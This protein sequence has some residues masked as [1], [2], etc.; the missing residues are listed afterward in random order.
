MDYSQITHRMINQEFQNQKHKDYWREK[1]RYIREQTSSTVNIYNPY[2]STK[3]MAH[4]NI[5]PKLYRKNPTVNICK[6]SAPRLSNSWQPNTN[7]LYWLK[8]IINSVFHHQTVSN[9]RWVDDAVHKKGKIESQNPPSQDR[10]FQSSTNLLNCSIFLPWTEMATLLDPN[11]TIGFN[12]P[13]WTNAMPN[14]PFCKEFKDKLSWLLVLLH[15]MEPKPLN[16]AISKQFSHIFIG[17]L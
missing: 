5:Y 16:W 3:T 8:L 10:I 11:N 9:L 6:E 17:N 14:S 7:T 2:F 12:H 13:H 1:S 15:L 4:K